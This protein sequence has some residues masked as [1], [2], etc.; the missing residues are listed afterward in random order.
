MYSSRDEKHGF[1]LPFANKNHCS[2]Y[3]NWPWVFLALYG[4][5][6][7]LT[8]AAT[9][10]LIVE[11]VKRSQRGTA[12]GVFYCVLGVSAVSSNIISGVLWDYVGREA[13]FV[14]GRI[15]AFLAVVVSFLVTSRFLRQVIIKE[16][17][18]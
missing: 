9:G 1:V 2:I 10:A 4:L 11:H 7:A 13:P 15:F 8:E 14:V 5:Y 16:L 17:S 12:L 3:M 18:V 6:L